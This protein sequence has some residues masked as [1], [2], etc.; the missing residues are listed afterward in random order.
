[1]TGANKPLAR[2]ILEAAVQLARELVR[3]EP[4]NRWRV[5]IYVAASR[6]LWQLDNGSSKEGVERW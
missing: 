5:F 3:V 2:E 1:M 6:K 4:L